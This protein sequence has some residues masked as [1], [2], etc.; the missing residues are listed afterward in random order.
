MNRQKTPIG[1]NEGFGAGSL[2]QRSNK[3]KIIGQQRA[4]TLCPIANVLDLVGDKW[5]LLIVR[6]M[7]LFNKHRY[8]DFLAADEGIPTNILADRLKRL[9]ENGLIEKSPYQ[10]HPVR[11]EYHLTDKGQDLEP[12][13][14]EMIHWGLKHI[15]G[16]GP[17][18]KAQEQ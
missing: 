7:L 18:P 10:H 4:N 2:S 6:D 3:G 17:R 15:P 16:T 1:F 9:E 11:Y 5:S 13:M 8:G 12:L 14:R